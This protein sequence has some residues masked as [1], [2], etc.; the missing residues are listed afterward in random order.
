MAR[1]LFCCEICGNQYLS[2]LENPNCKGCNSVVSLLLSMR[3]MDVWNAFL[4]KYSRVIANIAYHAVPLEKSE[5]FAQD[6]LM[7]IYRYPPASGWDSMEAWIRSVANNI[8]A[9][10]WRGKQG[11]GYKHEKEIESLETLQEEGKTVGMPSQNLDPESLLIFSSYKDRFDDALMKLPKIQRDPF[12]LHYF[13]G[14]TGEEISGV[15]S[16][17]LGTV[18]SRIFRA[19]EKLEPCLKKMGNY[20]AKQIFT[21]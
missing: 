15:L 6:I 17:P 10:W 19:T 4:N 5:D 21:S 3:D 9:S 2:V 18:K 14:L 11:K 13:Q 12:I 8:S 1:D 16:V 7:N 20:Y